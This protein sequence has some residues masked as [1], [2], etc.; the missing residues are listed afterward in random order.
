[1]YLFH[2]AIAKSLYMTVLSPTQDKMGVILNTALF[3]IPITIA[4]SA[5]TYRFLEKP[6]LELRVKYTK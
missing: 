5:I 6:F 1:M 2:L 4:V 3:I